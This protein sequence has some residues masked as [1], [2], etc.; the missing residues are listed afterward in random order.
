MVMKR[1]FISFNP[2]AICRHMFFR[3]SC[4]SHTGN[5]FPGLPVAEPGKHLNIS[6]LRWR[7]VW[8]TKVSGKP[9][10]NEIIRRFLKWRF[11]HMKRQA[12]KE[13]A[14]KSANRKYCLTLGLL[15]V[16]LVLVF[17]PIGTIV[18]GVTILGTVIVLFVCGCISVHEPS[19]N[20]HQ[21]DPSTRGH[22]A[23]EVPARDFTS[24]WE[25]GVPGPTMI[26][27]G[28]EEPSCE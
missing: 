14:M 2:P 17:S 27:N 18:A 26:D 13:S 8:Q 25:T 28:L 11:R 15:L 16:W 5:E 24:N 23:E 21:P 3:T 6:K 22:L 19:K 9:D 20:P 10:D 12:E 7:Q 1:F 4:P